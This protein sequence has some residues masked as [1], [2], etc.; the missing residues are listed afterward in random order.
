MGSLRIHFGVADLSRTQVLGTHDPMWE[1]VCA[2]HRLQTPLGRHDYTAWRQKLRA[3]LHQAGGLPAIREF[4]VPLL[5]RS[6]YFPDL[7]TP[8]PSADLDVTIDRIQRTDVRRLRRE[9]GRLDPPAYARNAVADVAAGRPA[10]L[11]RL[12]AA[13]RD[14]YRLAIEPHLATVSAT[15]A[16]DRA[17]RAAQVLTEGPGNLLHGLGPT[18]RWDPP[19]LTVAGYPV[20][21]D[22]ELGGRGLTLVPSYFCWR[23][24]IALADPDLPPVL[25]HPVQRASGE[26]VRPPPGLIRLLGRT[27]S[28]VLQ[29]TW[30]GA[31]TSE[32]A[33]LTGASLATVSEHATVLRNAGLIASH[34]HG[35]MMIHRVTDLGTSLLRRH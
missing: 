18:V 12:G 4:L 28:A 20:D 9:L 34:R 30:A 8:A 27:R 25:V 14:F 31:T 33:R 17:R 16:A 19:V 35:N 7:L 13:L 29:L 5:P 23:Y 24:P 11:N 6:A 26:L 15:L 21:R 1:T 22:L 10:A 3:N 2:V 32:L